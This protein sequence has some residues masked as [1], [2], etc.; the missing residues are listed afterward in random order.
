VAASA[1]LNA[2]DG[3]P[4][5]ELWYRRIWSFIAARFIDRQKGGW[6]A[7]LDDTLQPNAGPFFGKVDIYHSLQ[8]C[9]IPTLPTTGSVTRGL[10]GI[11]REGVSQCA[12]RLGF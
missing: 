3:D 8:A 1:F 10:V 2:I 11:G 7:Q 5:Y 6:R 9:L 12:S 4:V